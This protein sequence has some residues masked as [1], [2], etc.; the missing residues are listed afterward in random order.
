[1]PHR[2]LASP[3]LILGCILVRAYS[4]VRVSGGAL[5]DKVGQSQ[6]ELLQSS[7]TDWET[8]E[9][10]IEYDPVLDD[11]YEMESLTAL[12]D[13]TG[14]RYWTYGSHFVSSSTISNVDGSGNGTAQEALVQRFNRT[15]WLDT[16]VSYC[17][18]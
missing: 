4:V 16:T 7:A 10:V 3:V 9:A 1:M 17:Q 11:P 15:A 12:Y 6:R 18:W 13:A 2:Q 14:G 5:A 8:C